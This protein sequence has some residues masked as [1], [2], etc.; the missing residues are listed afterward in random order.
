MLTLTID[1]YD[2]IL[3]ALDRA[4]EEADEECAGDETG[5]EADRADAL[6]ALHEKLMAA[7]VSRPE[8]S[9]H[10]GSVYEL[11]WRL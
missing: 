2:M 4:A 8:A 9:K 6:G 10:G 11:A 3:D 1:E 5:P 7:R